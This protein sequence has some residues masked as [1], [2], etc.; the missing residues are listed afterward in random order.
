M[1]SDVDGPFS[2]KYLRE[3]ALDLVEGRIKGCINET[4]IEDKG[5]MARRESKLFAI[6]PDFCALLDVAR[7][8]YKENVQD[9]FNYVEDLNGEDVSDWAQEA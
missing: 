9:I 1:R 4:V 7:A 6:K 5:V 8:T 3:P 2:R